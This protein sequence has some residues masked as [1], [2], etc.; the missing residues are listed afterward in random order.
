MRL[1]DQLAMRTIFGTLFKEQYEI[2]TLPAE[3][4]AKINS[5]EL[6]IAALHLEDGWLGVAF[7]DLV[8]GQPRVISPDQYREGYPQARTS[9]RQTDEDSERRVIYSNR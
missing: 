3:A 8:T 4:L 2:G 9:Q 1:R 7:A 6:G 5:P